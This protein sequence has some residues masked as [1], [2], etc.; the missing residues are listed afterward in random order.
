[1]WPIHKHSG[2]VIGDA[3]VAETLCKNLRKLPHVESAEVYSPDAPIKFHLDAMVY[4]NETQPVREWADKHVLYWQNGTDSNIEEM[5]KIFYSRDCDGYAFFSRALLEQH[6][7]SGR[8]GI[9]LPF[10][11]DTS[12]YFPR[13]YE[14][15]LDFDVAYV[16]SDIKGSTTTMRYI[17]PALEFDFALF[18]GWKK[19]MR[20]KT[21]IESRPYRKKFESISRGHI[22]EADVPA[23]YSSSKI[24]L[25]TNIPQSRDLGVVSLR[26]YQVLACRGFLISDPVHGMEEE[27]RGKVV[28][29]N[30]YDDLTDKIKYYLAHDDERRAIAEKGYNYAVNESQSA[31]SVALRLFTYLEELCNDD[32]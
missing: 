24:I 10:C 32:N 8:K 21:R 15:R 16:G 19:P 25:N 17:Y 20:E 9:Y 2:N 18:G 12:F 28:F 3:L 4:M 31:A 26:T 29:T 7:S 23:M 30:G 1:M 27:L 5:F 6:I 11:A 14:E 22:P 13:D